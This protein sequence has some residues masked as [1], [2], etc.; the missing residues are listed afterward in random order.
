[1]KTVTKDYLET[2]YSDYEIDVHKTGDSKLVYGLVGAHNKLSQLA[3]EI[4]QVNSNRLFLWRQISSYTDKGGESGG[5]D[6]EPGHDGGSQDRR[7]IQFTIP[8]ISETKTNHIEIDI[9]FMTK[10]TEDFD[11]E[12]TL[13]HCTGEMGNSV[14]Y[15]FATNYYTATHTEAQDETG[16]FL[17]H[18][19]FIIPVTSV[20]QTFTVR[21]SVSGDD[22]FPCGSSVNFRCWWRS[23]LF[24]GETLTSADSHISRYSDDELKLSHSTIQ[25]HIEGLWESEDFKD[26]MKDALTHNIDD[27]TPSKDEWE[28]YVDSI[29]PISDVLTNMK[30]MLSSMLGNYPDPIPTESDDMI[31]MMNELCDINAYGMS[32]FTNQLKNKGINET[33]RLKAGACLEYGVARMP[34]HLAKSVYSKDTLDEYIHVESHILPI[35]TDITSRVNQPWR[36]GGTSELEINYEANDRKILSFDFSS[37][38][39]DAYYEM[40]LS[41]RMEPNHIS[42]TH[43]CV[44]NAYFIEQATTGRKGHNRGNNYRV[45]YGPRIALSSSYAVIDE[46]EDDDDTGSYYLHGRMIFKY[47]PNHEYCIKATIYGTEYGSGFVLCNTEIYSCYIKRVYA[48]KPI[49]FVKHNWAPY[50][51]MYEDASSEDV[52]SDGDNSSDWSALAQAYEDDR[53]NSNTVDHTSDDTTRVEYSRHNND[54]NRGLLNKHEEINDEDMGSI[55]DDIEE[56]PILPYS[57]EHQDYL[58][59]LK[60]DRIHLGGGV[61]YFDRFELDWN[62]DKDTSM[63]FYRMMHGVI[64]A[65]ECSPTILQLSGLPAYGTYD[66]IINYECDIFNNEGTVWNHWRD[67]SKMFVTF[68]FGTYA[69]NGDD[70]DPGDG[71]KDKES[72]IALNTCFWSDIEVGRKRKFFHN[73]NADPYDDDD[74][75]STN[76]G[77][78][79]GLIASGMIRVNLS[80]NPYPGIAYLKF[81][82]TDNE[83]TDD[84]FSNPLDDPNFVIVNG[85]RCGVSNSS[86]L[87]TKVSTS[88]KYKGICQGIYNL[89]NNRYVPGKNGGLVKTY[90]WGEIK[91]PVN[92]KGD[93]FV[94]KYGWHNRWIPGSEGL[95]NGKVQLG[96]KPP[97][98]WLS[99]PAISSVL[100]LATNVLMMA[101]MHN[102]NVK[103]VSDLDKCANAMVLIRGAEGVSDDEMK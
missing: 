85:T 57:V 18:G 58:Y 40:D 22:S 49:N 44:I 59:Q 6:I 28:S 14:R 55:E 15:G 101:L 63:Q 96:T 25:T 46:D 45:H 74:Y 66:F 41:F 52:L 47:N 20:T 83:E 80:D 13:L 95:P 17:I 37:L 62:K 81:S 50:R 35:W 2:E 4:N 39:E 12:E 79:F 102:T 88:S 94:V 91:Q 31:K 56:L 32:E 19:R 92:L 67:R 33:T 36:D 61:T 30:S 1:M 60:G 76:K 51:A 100:A 48:H 75:E 87:S 5:M 29:W 84:W 27:E 86:D 90:T 99:F 3:R 11:T 64:L 10:S 8:S 34:Q 103:Y 24:D 72:G 82:C 42:D 77:T 65:E 38:T 97:A 70:S 73:T 26:S 43:N 21:G 69:K 53:W 9:S 7:I 93:T 71:G 23:V 98:P 68:H 54:T 16:D 78:K 89:H